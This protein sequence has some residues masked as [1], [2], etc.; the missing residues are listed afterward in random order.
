MVALPEVPPLVIALPEAAPLEA[1]PPVA[2][3]PVAALPAVVPHQAVSAEP[4]QDQDAPPRELPRRER[5]SMRG[6]EP[7]AGRRRRPI[8]ATTAI[9]ATTAAT[10]TAAAARRAFAD[11]LSAF[12]QGIQDALAARGITGSLV[13]AMFNGATIEEG[14]SHEQPDRV[15]AQ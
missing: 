14:R 10:V 5:P 7:E 12:S 4:D 2:A 8:A 9:T 11:D 1:A 13:S 3:P 6:D 15:A